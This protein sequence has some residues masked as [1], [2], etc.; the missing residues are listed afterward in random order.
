MPTTINLPPD[1]RPHRITLYL[2]AE[3]QDIVP[4]TGENAGTPKHGERTTL[5]FEAETLEAAKQ[6]LIQF[7]IF[8]K[9]FS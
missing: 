6:K 7:L 5:T 1:E 3:I 2:L 4:A 8:A 9:H